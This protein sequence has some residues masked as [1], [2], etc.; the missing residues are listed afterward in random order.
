MDKKIDELI[1]SN[2]SY[3][4]IN[5]SDLNFSIEKLSSIISEKKEILSLY[6]LLEGDS[7][8]KCTKCDK[9]QKA[10]TKSEFEECFKLTGRYPSSTSCLPSDS[11]Y[12]CMYCYEDNFVDTDD[13]YEQIEDDELKYENYKPTG[14]V[15]IFDESDHKPFDFDQRV[16][17]LY[18][19][20]LDE[21]SP[22]DLLN[23]NQILIID[24][25]AD[26]YT[27]DDI[28]DDYYEYFVYMPYV[29]YRK[30]FNKD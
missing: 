3:L 29:I 14:K 22:I 9:W 7:I 23:Y 15:Y 11:Y 2:D 13:Y 6:V 26:D 28:N 1:A 20:R 19:R 30:N 24:Y 25:M 5:V 16:I 27:N 17:Y 12:D 8:R 4:E 18:D 21:R 10:K